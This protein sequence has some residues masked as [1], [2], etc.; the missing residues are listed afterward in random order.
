MSI[1][2]D[3]FSQE[4]I[5]TTVPD[6]GS[7]IGQKSLGLQSGKL[8]EFHNIGHIFVGAHECFNNVNFIYLFLLL[9]IK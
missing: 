3:S 1:K 4:F 6:E 2:D 9:A 7:R 5:A 8:S